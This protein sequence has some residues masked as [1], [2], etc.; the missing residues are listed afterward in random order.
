M[1]TSR[2]R[3][4]QGY[5]VHAFDPA[6]SATSGA[7]SVEIVLGGVHIAAERPLLAH[8]DG[9]VLLHALCDAL[10]GSLALGDIGKH[11]PD[12]SAEFDNIDS[13]ELLRR[14]VELIVERGFAVVNVDTTIVAQRP[15]LASFIDQ[16]RA[17]V[18]S[19]LGLAVDDVSVKATTTEQLGFIGREEGI[20]CYATV[21]VESRR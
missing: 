1:S 4:G 20:A 10:L 7:A 6:A 16:M 2:I 13:R 17:N 18:A 12:T 15:K 5:D 14:V 8:S 11:F 9:D 21:L 19:D 3:I